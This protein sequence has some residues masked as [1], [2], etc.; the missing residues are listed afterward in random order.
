[1]LP[2]A[3]RRK[4]L[5]LRA[6]TEATL[7]WGTERLS[8]HL[9]DLSPSG[10]CFSTEARIALGDAVEISVASPSARIEPLICRGRAVRAERDDVR[11]IIGVEFDTESV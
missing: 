2:D 4:F 3:E 5:R 7:T 10:C 9:I 1:M 11:L 8:V 6:D